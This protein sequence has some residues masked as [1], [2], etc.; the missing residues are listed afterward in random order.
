MVNK[1]K[2]LWLPVALAAGLASTGGVNAA[3][4]TWTGGGADNNW[5]TAA[6]WGGPVW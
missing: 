6:N 3:N 2:N 5:G 1:F 4:A